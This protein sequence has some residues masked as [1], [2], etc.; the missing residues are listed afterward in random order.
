[1]ARSIS[2][3]VFLWLVLAE[4]LYAFPDRDARGE[5]IENF[6]ALQGKIHL[7]LPKRNFEERE[8]IALEYSIRNTGKEVVRIFPAG[9]YRYSFQILIKDGEDRLLAPLEDPEFHDPILK[10]RTTI[11]NLVGD[12]NKEII[13][14]KGESFSR[15]IYLDELYAF[16]PGKKYYVTGYFYPNYTE[17]KRNFLRSENTVSFLL[18]SRPKEKVSSLIQLPGQEITK[19]SPE[20]TLFLFLG[21]EMKKNWEGHFK[22]IHFPEYILN[23]DRFSTIYSESPVGEREAIIQEFKEY[24]TSSPSGV[25]KYFKILSVEY[26][27]VRDARVLVYVERM[28]GR[29]KSRYEYQYSLHLDMNDRSALWQIKNVLVKV[30]K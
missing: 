8:R 16:E 12:A 25:L 18:Q 28:Q 21:S 17:D 2:A 11:V 7:E 22:W 26:P 15:T 3:F 5:S 10:R 1:M 24:L 29:F 27:S 20:E 9:D 30:K 6:L 4:I 23:Y 19:L 14:H 13:L